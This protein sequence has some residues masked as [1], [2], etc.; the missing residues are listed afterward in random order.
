MDRF[1]RV[2]LVSIAVTLCLCPP[3][4]LLARQH[5]SGAN[6]SLLRAGVDDDDPHRYPALLTYN[7]IIQLYQHDIP[8]PALQNKLQELL[9]IP[10]VNNQATLS[11]VNPIMPSSP[12]LGRFLRVVEW[13]IERGLEFD[14]LRLAFS[15]AQGFSKLM[16]EKGSAVSEIERAQILDQVK[17]LRDADLLIFNEVDWGL[18]RTLFRNVTAELAASLRMNYAYGVE[19]VEVDPITMGIDDQ[20]VLRE[21]EKAHVES[22]NSK[23]EMIAY[24]KQLMKPDPHQY[25]GLHGTAILSRYPISNARLIPF[26]SQG[27]DWYADEKKR[28][29]RIAKIEDKVSKDVFKEQLVRQV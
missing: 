16:D 17:L 7:E 28:A 12:Q 20:V 8:D 4:G 3:P 25:R 14:A 21:V 27:H 23:Q 26:K 5:Q 15:D 1:T 2:A 10:F 18:N 11:G 6:E 24:V 13:N 9:T 29:S 19:F 22:A